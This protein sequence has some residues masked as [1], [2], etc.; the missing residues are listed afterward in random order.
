[1]NYL[2]QLEKEVAAGAG[3]VF[4]FT[5]PEYSTSV[6]HFKILVGVDESQP[7]K[8]LL[9]LTCTS[10]S[11]VMRSYVSIDNVLLIDNS[12]Y[13]ELT[14]ETSILCNDIESVTVDDL[15]DKCYTDCEFNVCKRISNDLLKRLYETIRDSREVSKRHKKIIRKNLHSRGIIE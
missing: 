3:A 9:F 6:P 11:I 5:N 4:R 8:M 14:E 12:D 1:M 2:D 10:K 15:I 7:R 13:C